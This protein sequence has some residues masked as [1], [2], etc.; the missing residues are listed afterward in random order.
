[1]GLSIGLLGVS[2]EQ[3]NWDFFGAAVW[4]YYMHNN[5]MMHCFSKKNKIIFP[6]MCLIAANILEVEYLDNTVD[7]LSCHACERKT[8]CWHAELTWQTWWMLILCITDCSVPFLDDLDLVLCTQSIVLWMYASLNVTWWEFQCVLHVFSQS[9][10][11]FNRARQLYKNIS[12]VI[13]V[14]G[15]IR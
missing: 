3:W 5:A 2:Q 13:S 6:A 1:V 8:Y 10:T 12:Y 15:E 14:S 7:W 9:H 11:V 4:L